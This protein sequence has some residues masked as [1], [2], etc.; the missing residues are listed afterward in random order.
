MRINQDKLLISKDIVIILCFA[1][2]NNVIILAKR[3]PLI[4]YLGGAHQLY[5]CKPQKWQFYDA[6]C[7]GIRRAKKVG[8][9]GYREY[10][11][12]KLDKG[13]YYNLPVPKLI[14]LVFE[15]QVLWY[16]YM[17]F[18][19]HQQL[20]HE[21]RVNIGLQ[22]WQPSSLKRLYKFQQ[23]IL[24]DPVRIP[25]WD[26]HFSYSRPNIVSRQTQYNEQFTPHVFQWHSDTY[27][28]V[29]LQFLSTTNA[30]FFKVHIIFTLKTQTGRGNRLR[31]P[32]GPVHANLPPVTF[33]TI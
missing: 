16:K 11:T 20:T 10:K 30:T 32:S 19:T 17:Q 31:H 21:H 18:E 25:P 14:V 13:R 12:Q 26:N 28:Y 3:G 6:N 33:I 9:L 27:D 22:L 8:K 2:Q 5:V 7:N 24:K 1:N 4:V 23:C 29:C 15:R